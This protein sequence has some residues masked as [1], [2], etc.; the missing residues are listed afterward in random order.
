MPLG[1]VLPGASV[2]VGAGDPVVVYWN[3]YAVL[4]NAGDVG[5]PLVMAGAW[6]IVK[7]ALPTS[8][9]TM[10]ACKRVVDGRK[11][12]EDD[13]R[14]VGQIDFLES[15]AADFAGGEAVLRAVRIVCRR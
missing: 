13:V 9:L 15:V 11:V 6:L 10:G 4:S 8:G 5:G 7:V 3:E 2:N 14:L 12:I 1:S